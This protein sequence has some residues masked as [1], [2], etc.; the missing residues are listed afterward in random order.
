[1]TAG[2]EIPFAVAGHL[3]TVPSPDWPNF[4]VG[5]AYIE[6]PMAEITIVVDGETFT[7]RPGTAVVSR[8]EPRPSV[9]TTISLDCRI[10]A[11]DEGSYKFAAL[12]GYVD[13]AAGVFY[14][15]D[16]VDRL[17]EAAP[18]AV[19]PW[20]LLPLGA[21]IAVVAVVGGVIYVTEKRRE[22]ML[23]LMR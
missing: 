21:G 20:W 22:E 9:C 4:A 7:L 2:E 18:A 23:L 5:F 13:V 12:T 1:M 10:K 3:H 6:G 16:R 17:V 14:Y 19:W 15:D 11:L 8:I